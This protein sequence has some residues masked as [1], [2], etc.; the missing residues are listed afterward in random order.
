MFSR[1]NKPLF[2]ALR[3]HTVCWG[4]CSTHTIILAGEH[5]S[6]CFLHFIHLLILLAYCRIPLQSTGNRDFNFLCGEVWRMV[7]VM[8]L[9]NCLNPHAFYNM[10]ANVFVQEWGIELSL[11]SR[12]EQQCGA[13]R[14]KLHGWVGDIS[15]DIS[16]YLNQQT[17]LSSSI[18]SD[19]PRRKYKYPE[20]SHQSRCER[21]CPSFTVPLKALLRCICIFG[22]QNNGYTYDVFLGIQVLGGGRDQQ[23][24]WL[25]QYYSL[26]SCWRCVPVRPGYCWPLSAPLWES[27][28]S[29][30]W[31]RSAGRCRFSQCFQR[32][33]KSFRL[34]ETF[35]L[36]LI[37]QYKSLTVLSIQLPCHN[38]M[39]GR[40][41]IVLLFWL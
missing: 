35:V 37:T 21:S 33:Y 16:R 15:R 30:P 40:G 14:S 26:R 38:I 2:L 31:I 3:S 4:L 22:V 24:L 11:L 6:W 36:T 20:L 18:L 25:H 9:L 27:S 8:K 32:R 13:S 29:I 41:I 19:F 1:Q 28:T 10:S 7:K 23:E 39:T 5:L 34:I 17:S 12:Q